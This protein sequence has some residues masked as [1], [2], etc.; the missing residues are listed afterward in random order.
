VCGVAVNEP[1]IRVW[2]EAGARETGWLSCPAQAGKG[3]EAAGRCRCCCCRCQ[4]MPRRWTGG[5]DSGVD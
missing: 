1:E 3:Q 2:D 5:G 4:K